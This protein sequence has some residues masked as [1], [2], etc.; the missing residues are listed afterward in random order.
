VRVNVTCVTPL[1]SAAVRERGEL[2][3]IAVL[4]SGERLRCD[5]HGVSAV[6]R[7]RE[8]PECGD[9]RDESGGGGGGEQC[10]SEAPI[11][12]V[13]RP[14]PRCTSPHQDPTAPDNALPVATRSLQP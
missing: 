11:D 4:D 8:R 12:G 9:R 2:S 14:N 3:F 10:Y 5:E 1:G 7:V 13:D 6:R